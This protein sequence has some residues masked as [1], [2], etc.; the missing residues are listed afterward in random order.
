MPQGLPKKIEID[1]LLADLALK[2]RNAPARRRKIL[3]RLNIEH[4]QSLA[5]PTG[6]PQRLHAAPAEM[7]APAV[8]IPRRNP[9]LAGQ[10]RNALSRQQPL[11]SRNLELS[12]ELT[13]LALGHRSLLENCLLF[14]VSVLG[15][16]PGRAAMA[17]ELRRLVGRR[18]NPTAR[19]LQKQLKYKRGHSPIARSRLRGTQA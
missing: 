6:R 2:L 3:A 9:K 4:P 11:H 15:C 7:P 19:R 8:K 17:P 5:R 12:A 18:A 10:R 1:L 14:R 16:T 13:T